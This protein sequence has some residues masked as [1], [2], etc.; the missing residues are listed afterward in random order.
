MKRIV[1]IGGYGA[2][3]REAAALLAGWYPG[4]V[5]LAGRHP[6][7]ARPVP[8]TTAMRIDLDDL[9]GVLD[10]TDAVVMCVD[11][12][13]VRVARA[14]FERGIH[15]VDVSASYDVLAGIERLDGVAAER[16]ASGVLS[17]GLAPG[18]TNLLARTVGGPDVR[19][20]VLIG[21]GEAHGPAALEWTLDGLAAM[22][23]SWPMPFTGYGTRTVHA[24]PFS[25]QH[26][27]RRTLGAP[28]VAT[29]LCLDSR[30]MTAALARLAR[31]S[32]LLSRPRIRAG[33][34]ATLGRVHV[35]SDGFAVTV[36]SGEQ[37]A[38]FGGRR[39]SRATGVVAALAVRRLE[40]FAPGV[41]HLDELVEPAAFL[42]QVAEYGFTTMPGDVT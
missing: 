27:L 39:Q 11:H 23:S 21:S 3:G 12:G 19:I 31:L 28:A 9:D 38:S 6:E 22:G 24:F 40:T 42:T 25:D 8:G 20:G 18:V 16:G 5:V 33:V 34:L 29:G 7:R 4:A 37:V 14:C 26:T 17:V 10:G 13:N 15:Y 32:G 36:T 1:L 41:R 2:V 30:I 35:G